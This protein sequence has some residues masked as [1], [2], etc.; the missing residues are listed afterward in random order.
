MDFAFADGLCITLRNSIGLL[1]GSHKDSKLCHYFDGSRFTQAPSTQFGHNSGGLVALKERALIV[2][3]HESDSNIDKYNLQ[4][5]VLFT[6]DN[7]QQQWVIDSPYNNG[8][9]SLGA[10]VKSQYSDFT[11]VEL[12][13][14][15]F[16]FGGMIDG[17]WTASDRV[18][19]F[20]NGWSVS[21]QSVIRRSEHKKRYE[22]L[23]SIS[24]PIGSNK[25]HLCRQCAL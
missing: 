10:L 11:L 5:E 15:V 24:Q 9:R 20:D 2:A 3:G 25:L 7:T 12:N 19:I 16:A 23:P 8:S 14:Q 18:F 13:G 17:V 1:C 21:G 4:T 22:N 6:F